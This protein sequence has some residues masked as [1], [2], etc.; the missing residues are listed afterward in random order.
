VSEESGQSAEDVLARRAQPFFDVRVGDGQPEADPV[1]PHGQGQFEVFFPRGAPHGHGPAPA[2]GLEQ[3]P[4]PRHQPRRVRTA[5]GASRLDLLHAHG[6]DPVEDRVLGF[7]VEVGAEALVAFAQGGIDEHVASGASGGSYGPPGFI[8][9]R[10]LQS[11][12]RSLTEKCGFRG[13]TVH[14]N[15][16]F[17]AFFPSILCCHVFNVKRGLKN[18]LIKLICYPIFTTWHG[19]C[20]RGSHATR[21]RTVAERATREPFTR[22]LEAF[23]R[24][25]QNAQDRYLR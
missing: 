15:Y 13:E 21:Q 17:V 6:R 8:H 20:P 11:K 5:S 22:R 7:G 18:T 24:R 2:F 12:K 10:P 1:R 3:F 16:N 4:R 19:P 23:R 14:Y 9:S 25:N